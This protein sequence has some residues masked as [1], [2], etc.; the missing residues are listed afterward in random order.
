[1]KDMHTD[2]ITNLKLIM[3]FIKDVRGEII[4]ITGYMVCST[5]IQVPVNCR[6]GICR[7]SSISLRC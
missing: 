3:S 5:R 4:E 1:M 7:M 2:F 6:W